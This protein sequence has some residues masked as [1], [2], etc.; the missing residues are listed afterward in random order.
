[1]TT[2]RKAFVPVDEHEFALNFQGIKY[3]FARIKKY[4][5]KD[6]R[7]LI[8]LCDACFSFSSFGLWRCSDAASDR[9]ALSAAESL[10][11]S[12]YVIKTETCALKYGGA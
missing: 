12:E 11:L 9:E 5:L 10:H 4:D 1:V 3:S 2:R 7:G 6:N 8:F